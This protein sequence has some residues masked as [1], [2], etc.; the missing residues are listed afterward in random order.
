MARV[1]SDLAAVVEFI[2]HI[3]EGEEGNGRD[4]LSRSGEQRELFIRCSDIVAVEHRPRLHPGAALDPRHVK[5][6]KRTHLRCLLS[7][8]IQSATLDC[9]I[10]TLEAATTEM[11]FETA[12]NSRNTAMALYASTLSTPLFTASHT[13]YIALLALSSPPIPPSVMILPHT[14][15]QTSTYRRACMQI[16][17]HRAQALNENNRDALCVPRRHNSNSLSLTL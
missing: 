14:N 17:R 9:N 5:E 13:I 4:G 3:Y 6:V 12:C 2:L 8:G 1:R 7:E 15:A 16:A 10:S 11:S